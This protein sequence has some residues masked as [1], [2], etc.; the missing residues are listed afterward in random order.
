MAFV[1]PSEGITTS[2]I[3]AAK[4]KFDSLELDFIEAVFRWNFD[5]LHWEVFVVDDL[6]NA[7]AA[8][9]DGWE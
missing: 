1:C 8:G 9:G 6:E 2:D 7:I 4:A 5:T 3:M